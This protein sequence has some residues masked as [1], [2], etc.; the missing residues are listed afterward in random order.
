M[1]LGV[2]SPRSSLPTT[3]CPVGHAVHDD[4]AHCVRRSL[5]YGF[6]YS[7]LRTAHSAQH[8]PLFSLQEDRGTSTYA[9]LDIGDTLGTVS[10]LF[11]IVTSATE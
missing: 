2:A 8:T 4:I 6:E 5:T 9:E 1:R 11:E 10:V 3:Q 7:V